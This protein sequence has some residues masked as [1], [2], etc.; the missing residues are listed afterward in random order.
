MEIITI[1]DKLFF[2]KNNLEDDVF[3]TRFMNNHFKNKY[4]TFTSR[5]CIHYSFYNRLSKTIL[6][7]QKIFSFEKYQNS[8]PSI[9]I[10]TVILFS[11]LSVSILFF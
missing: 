5:I 11:K 7:K 1:S 4:S 6:P 10:G 9:V 8:V 3:G 2:R